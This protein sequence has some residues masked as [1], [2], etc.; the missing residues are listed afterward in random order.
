MRT[1]YFDCFSG[2]SGDMLLGALVD[3]GVDMTTL[4]AAVAGLGLDGVRLV[5]SRVQRRTL[6][7][8]KID[9]VVGGRTEGPEGRVD[10][11]EHGESRATSASVAHDHHHAP[12]HH[13]DR[14]HEHG[15]DRDGD[16]AAHEHTSHGASRNLA[17]ILDLIG[18]A[19][20]PELTRRRAET[21]FRRLGDAE[22]RMH[23]T[24]IDRV[25]LHE[26]GALDA[27]VDVVGAML[28]VETLGIERFVCSPLNLGS[29]TVRFSHGTFPV[30]APATAELLR[31]APVYAGDVRKELT[32]P[33]GAA[34]VST[35]AD[36]YGPLPAMRI[37]A[38]GYGAGS[39]DLQGHPNVLRLVLGETERVARLP[40]QANRVAVLEAAIDDM[41]AESF[42]FFIERALTEGALDVYTVPALMKKNRPGVEVT[43]VCAPEDLDRMI[44]L[45]FAET[46]TLGL[47]HRLSERSVLD[48][49]WVTVVT[50]A[51]PI[52]VKV[53][54]L[55]E[56]VM[57]ASPEYD[58]CRE[59]ALRTGLPIKEIQ[60]MA[61]A[62]YRR[63]AE[64]R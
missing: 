31:G 36:E 1:L 13:H 44:R 19:T 46:T 50:T 29:G 62:E 25:H 27:V 26:V 40:G 37:D 15:H 14:P 7:A 41:T 45:V 9:V 30:P 12:P 10:R 8:V 56:S 57:G 42:G 54:R 5:Q 35:L 52:R 38:I 51:G 55:G 17:E 34:V 3:L 11:H 20:L 6:S 64:N 33:T 47:R 59:A 53:G 63:T 2:I 24:T 61:V 18:A 48:R 4:E 23:G 43:V 60:A 39:R 49:S 22:A 16:D 28:A 32:T 21:A 58:D